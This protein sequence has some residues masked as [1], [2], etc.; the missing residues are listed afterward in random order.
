MENDD[1]KCL[2]WPIF[3]A[4]HPF[5]YKQHPEIVS[6]FIPFEKEIIMDGVS[7]PVAIKDTNQAEENYI[8]SLEM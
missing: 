8:L 4:L 7:Y 3:A 5:Y 6:K 2:L 1:E